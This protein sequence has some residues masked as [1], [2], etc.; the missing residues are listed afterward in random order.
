M[1]GGIRQGKIRRNI[2]G[3]MAEGGENL[4][5]EFKLTPKPFG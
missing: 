1:A 2:T 4:R 3:V 5:H